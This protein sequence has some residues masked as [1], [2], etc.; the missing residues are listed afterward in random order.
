MCF[1]VFNGN[2]DDKILACDYCVVMIRKTF[3]S[4]NWIGCIRQ[5]LLV[6]SSWPLKCAKLRPLLKKDG[7]WTN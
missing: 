7:V 1:D 5:I 3:F 6:F 2:K 4:R